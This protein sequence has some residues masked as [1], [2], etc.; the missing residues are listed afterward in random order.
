MG[1]VLSKPLEELEK[2]GEAQP[3]DRHHRLVVD[4]I[5]SKPFKLLVLPIAIHEKPLIP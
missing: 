2:P 4:T 3:E 5:S 1:Y